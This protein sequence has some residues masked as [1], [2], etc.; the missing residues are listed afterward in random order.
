MPSHYSNWFA[1][2]RISATTRR[3]LKLKAAAQNRKK[4]GQFAKG[5]KTVNNRLRRP[6]AYSKWW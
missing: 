4:N 3:L 1:P 5:R 2:R 6:V